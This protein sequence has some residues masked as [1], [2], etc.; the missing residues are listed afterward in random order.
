MYHHPTMLTHEDELTHAE[1]LRAN[2]P[3]AQMAELLK[4]LAEVERLSDELSAFDI[5]H[6]TAVNDHVNKA[7]AYAQ[8]GR[9]WLDEGHE[10]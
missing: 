9:D 4:H 5:P 10:I 3:G 1:K 6:I 8:V 7:I 2:H